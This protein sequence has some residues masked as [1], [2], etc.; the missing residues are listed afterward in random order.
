[1][2]LIIVDPISAYLG[3]TDSHKNAEVRSL[4]GPMAMLAMKRR[5]AILAITHLSR[6]QNDPLNRLSGSIA[7]GAAARTVWLVAKDPENSD[8]RFFLSLK[9]NLAREAEGMAFKPIEDEQGRGVIAWEPDPVDITATDLM[10]AM[11]D[12]AAQKLEAACSLIREVLADG[13]H[14]LASEL[15]ERAEQKGISKRTITAARRLLAIKAHRTGY[16]GSGKWWLSL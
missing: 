12:P 13:D 6:N 5:V 8:R 9:N 4:L 2:R 15:D 7:F 11:H 16:G 3:G 10:G 1:V 14:H